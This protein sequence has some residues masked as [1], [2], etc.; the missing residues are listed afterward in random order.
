VKKS[1]KKEHDLL[2][3][4][5]R[6]YQSITRD[7]IDGFWIIDMQG[8]FLDVNDSYCRLVGYSRKELLKMNIAEVEVGGKTKDI[9]RRLKSIKRM[10]TD[11][12][13]TQHREKSGKII[14][15]E[16][17]ANYANYSGGFILFFLRGI[18]E[19]KKTESDLAQN[20]AKSKKII[21]KQLSDAYQHLGLINRKISLLLEIG[22]FPKSKKH[23]QEIIDHVLNLAMSIS[24]APAGYLYGSRER[25]K[26]SLLSYKGLKEEQKEKI[27]VITTQTVGLL[28]H[29]MTQ[30]GLISGDIKRYEAE[31]LAL[32]NKLEYFVTLP[33]SKGSS[34][35]GFIFLGFDKKKNVDMQDLEFLDVFATHASNALIKAGVLK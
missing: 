3:K 21:E 30:K 7:S 35:G 27:E 20:R 29:L 13:L 8:R 4:T 5:A 31:L 9:A 24:K 25:G 12:F 22:K 16:A 10:G 26:F 28:R 23:R 11:R 1:N 2:E 15:I 34:L 6:V 17:T 14:D 33:L 18:S 32:D 19:R